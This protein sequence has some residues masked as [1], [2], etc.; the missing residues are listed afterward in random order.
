MEKEYLSIKEFAAVVGVSQ[1]AIY[2]QLNNRLKSYLKVV[3]G[4][5]MLEK[6]ALDLF[7]KK[8]N[9][10]DMQQQLLNMLQTELNEKNQQ[11][12][13]KDKQISEL[14]KLLDQ[15]QKLNAMDKQKILELEDKMAAADQKQS[16][17][18]EEPIKKKWWQKFF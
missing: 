7:K 2:K 9:S 1:Q 14:Q 11:L 15:A 5:K 18:V 6:S 10:I 13:E 17:E 16:Q 12:N 4:K 3:D 8:E